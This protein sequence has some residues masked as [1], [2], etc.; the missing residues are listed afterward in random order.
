MKGPV[1]L[2]YLIPN[3]VILIVAGSYYFRIKHDLIQL[4]A[5]MTLFPL[6]G[7]QLIMSGVALYHWFG[8]KR[9]F[10]WLWGVNFAVS[11]FVLV[12]FLK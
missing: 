11:V 3:A 4:L 12:S 5:E 8:Q 9:P 2:L 1:Y 7:V 10:H 6:M